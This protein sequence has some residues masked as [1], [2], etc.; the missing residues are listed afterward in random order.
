MA[1]CEICEKKFDRKGGRSKLCDKCWLS[2][3]RFKRVNNSVNNSR[4]EVTKVKIC[5][6]CRKKRLIYAKGLCASCYSAQG[7]KKRKKNEKNKS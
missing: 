1:I 5:I 6:R 2:R 3:L 7:H 4:E